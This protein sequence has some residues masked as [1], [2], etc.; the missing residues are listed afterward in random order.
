MSAEIGSVP[1]ECFTWRYLA[2]H[3]AADVDEARSEQR[4][5]G[6]NVRF[7]PSPFEL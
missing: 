6:V 2:V 3:A 7:R 5:R 1:H 4:V